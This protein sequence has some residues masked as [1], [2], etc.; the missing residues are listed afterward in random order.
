[1]C[2]IIAVYSNVDSRLSALSLHLKVTR[3]YIFVVC[4]LVSLL[5]ISSFLT[6]YTYKYIITK[7]RREV[8][9]ETDFKQM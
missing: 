7:Q 8:A 4:D 9:I 2:S 6:L 1:M 5:M 3:E